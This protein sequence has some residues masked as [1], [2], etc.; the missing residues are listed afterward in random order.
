VFREMWWMG[1]Q[2]A[3]ASTT[4]ATGVAAAA[5]DRSF[6]RG[7]RA[8]RRGLIGPWDSS[9]PPG[10]SGYL[11]FSGVARLQ[12]VT[13]D[14]WVLP[15]GRVVH[16]RGRWQGTVEIG[17]PPV[18]VNRHTIVVAPARSGK[19]AGVIA[20]WIAEAA[21]AGYR[22]VTVDVKGNDDLL[23]EVV[24]YRDGCGH[25][26]PLPVTRW[27][28]CDP[29]QSASWNFIADL[30]GEGELNA[31]AEA[32]C[33]LPRDNDPNRNFHLR[34][35]KWAKG[36]LQLSHD[37]GRPVTVRHL[38]DL[39]AHPAA[40]R[41]AVANLPRSLGAHRLADLVS[42][43]DSEVS[44]AT[45]F[46]STYFESLNVD[47]FLQV[48][49]QP[50]RGMDDLTGRPGGITLIDAPLADGK[51]AE[52]ASALFLTMLIQRRLAGFGQG[53]PLL[54]VLD[55]SPRLQNRIN[56]GQVL[57]VA[58]GAN[59]S[60]LLAAQDVGQFEKER[61]DEILA[62]C[63]TFVLLGGAGPESTDYAMRRLGTR[64]RSVRTESHSWDRRTG[65]AISYGQSSE[66]VPVLGHNEL[67]HPPAG[68]FGATVLNQRLSARP[69]LID[70]ARSDL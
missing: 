62:N 56:L 19:T 64:I 68:R 18:E 37:T 26:A 65:Q 32:I 11:D 23:S 41:N 69:I 29:A 40:L 25:G 27:N 46:L 52:T 36:L 3:R 12:D 61:R 66:S 2:T 53:P 63:G 33:G 39:L 58:A 4:V 42:M 1:R 7:S 47:R 16:P 55:E 13:A 44:Q 6:R 22:V 45:Q 51:L 70:L 49:D 38:L 10:V 31:V 48:T 60:V 54:L 15:L 24:S 43:T 35:L 9:P 28:Y 20:P 57:A 67:T 17:L 8:A 5:A 34:D 50:E 14:G 59:V 30:R 21:W